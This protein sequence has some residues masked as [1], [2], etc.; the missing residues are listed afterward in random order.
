[1]VAAFV[2]RFERAFEVGNGLVEE[3]VT[4]DSTCPG[5]TFELVLLRSPEECWSVDL[6]F[7][8]NAD[9]EVPICNEG[10]PML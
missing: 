3:P 5:D 6:V 10:V 9:S 7:G 1:M 2:G 8:Q 4:V